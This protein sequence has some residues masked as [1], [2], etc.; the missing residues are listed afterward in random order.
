MYLANTYKPFLPLCEILLFLMP[1]HADKNATLIKCFNNCH[2]ILRKYIKYNYGN[3]VTLSITGLK[4]REKRTY[5]TK[6][7]IFNI[8]EKICAIL[9]GPFFSHIQTQIASHTLRI[10]QVVLNSV[11]IFMWLGQILLK[12]IYC[13]NLLKNPIKITNK[14]TVGEFFANESSSQLDNLGSNP[15]QNHTTLILPGCYCISVI[16]SGCSH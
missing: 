10:E 5:E 6:C 1:N 7:T 12:S 15:I 9:L 3:H 2:T 14:A 16:I 13:K 4:L 8:R 11:H